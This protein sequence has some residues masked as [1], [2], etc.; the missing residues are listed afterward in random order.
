M[1][2]IEWRKIGGPETYQAAED[3][4]ED[5][6]A[7]AQAAATPNAAAA[8]QAWQAH[9]AST[10][11]QQ[12]LVPT[13]DMPADFQS[14]DEWYAGMPPEVRVLDRAVDQAMGAL[15]DAIE[16]GTCQPLP[17]LGDG[18][19]A[20]KLTAA[21][22]SLGA[23][24]RAA[25]PDAAEIQKLASAADEALLDLVSGGNAAVRDML[26]KVYGR[27][28]AGG[29]AFGN[30]VASRLGPDWPVI[31]G[32]PRA[33]TGEPLGRV[34]RGGASQ[35]AAQSAPAQAGGAPSQTA[36]AQ[37]APTQAGPPP[38]PAAPGA[39]AGQASGASGQLDQALAELARAERQLEQAAAQLAQTA[40]SGRPAGGAHA[41]GGTK[42]NQAH[43]APGGA[44]AHGGAT[45]A[46]GPAAPAGGT[47]AHGGTQGAGGAHGPA[48]S[49]KGG[50]VRPAGYDKLDAARAGHYIKNGSRGEE[51]KALQVALNK[52]GIE[53]PLSEDGIAGPKTVAAIRKFQQEHGCTVDG[54]VGPQTMAA[55]DR[56][57]GLPTPQGAGGP[58]GAGGAREAAP[59]GQVPRASGPGAPAR[60]AAL[61]A[62]RSQ[63]GVREASGNNDGLPAQRYAGGRN[64]PWCADFVSW[65]FRQAGHPLP[66]NQRSIAS[67]NQMAAELAARGEIYRKGSQTPQPGD[68]IFFGHYPGGLSHVGIVDH[69]S[70]GTVY[71]VEGNSG[72]LQSTGGRASIARLQLPMR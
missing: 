59:S 56:A 54:I 24:L 69:V 22:E 34:P 49:G 3:V 8:A 47:K 37:A 5:G 63:V 9:Q 60:R 2:G 31:E 23:A 40:Q 1:S 45:K 6:G 52:A 67:C 64:E 25:T 16:T 28:A 15:A 65:S 13:G 12:R 7:A 29:G 72:T 61:E 53:P 68:I 42:G 46:H 21:L 66:G 18:G 14:L 17:G 32:P 20:A 39:Q 43:H 11:E 27:S 36:P 33:G 70:N 44:Q 38:A 55:L 50:G 10:I 19:A 51:V 58:G 48:Q 71:T 4:A 57:L 62:A 41:A 35:P 30:A 26:A